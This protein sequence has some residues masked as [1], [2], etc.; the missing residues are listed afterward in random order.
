MELDEL[1]ESPYRFISHDDIVYLAGFLDGEGTFTVYCC[2]GTRG[3]VY[4]ALISAAGN[5]EVVMQWLQKTFGGGLYRP[6]TK[7]DNR[8]QIVQWQIRNKE[9]L[10]GLLPLLIEHLKTKK[11][12][13]RLLLKYSVEYRDRSRGQTLSEED[14]K[15]RNAYC[16]LFSDLNSVGKTS[17]AKKATVTSLFASGE[18]ALP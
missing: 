8:A 7:D 15:L 9:L 3:P 16:T 12:Q 5:D 2:E 17:T 10:I 14:I 11:L 18:V 6:K 13:A 1:L 4:S